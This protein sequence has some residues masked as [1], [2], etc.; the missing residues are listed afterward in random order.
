[1][2]GFVP[3][4]SAP[5]LVEMAAPR[6]GASPVEL[7]SHGWRYVVTGNTLL[8]EK[9]IRD[10]LD[11][12]A[13]PKAALG[14][15]VKAYHAA[16]YLLVAATGQV[17]GKKV[18]I[19]VYEGMLTELTA[20]AGLGQFF[21][22]I[23]ERRDLRQPAILK[24]QIM[25]GAYA[26][27]SGQK[28]NVNLGPAANPGGSSLT[29][30]ET[31][32]P[33]YFPVSGQVTFGNYGS[34]FS[35]GYVVGGSAAANLT[36]GVQLTANYLQGLPGLRESSY[37]SSYEQGGVGASVVTPYGIYGVSFS[38][39]YFR[40]GQETWP[41]NPKGAA[42]TFQLTGTQLVYADTATRVSLTESLT[43][44]TY[45]ETVFNGFFTLL[46][47]PYNYVSLG[48]SAS[49]SMTLGGLPGTLSGG[50]TFN[51]GISG[52][53]GT[54]YD[55]IPGVPTSHFRYT[56]FTAAYHQTLPKGFTAD[57]TG[58]AQW[59]VNTVPTQQQWTLGGFGNLAA[60]EPG[61]T[62]GDSGYIAR[63]E[64]DAPPVKRFG[65]SATFGVFAETGG[66][67]FSH[68]VAR[69]PPWQLLSDVGLILKLKLPYGF[70]ATAMAAKNVRES[71]FGAAGEANLKLNRMS[72]FFVVQKGF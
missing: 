69:T 53:S 7:E 44:V 61:I 38:R 9:K 27:R 29:V 48:T 15:L 8:A 59:A 54:L 58:L 22:G 3:P 31:P 49:H 17:N 70:S 14:D 36:H 65:T 5:T 71:G 25:A 64:L 60:W 16:G 18:E 43:R 72:A 40:L 19:A 37:G 12:A 52:A 13:D 35:S 10:V 56:N 23:K 45:K 6:H 26:E 39:L 46:D 57:L 30:S 34:R 47:Q 1:M 2:A 28:L 41:L 51:M 62:V 42:D 21:G 33:N 4:P 55:N 68:P 66:A 24:R 67:T 11:R 32:T 63:L 20:P 50:V